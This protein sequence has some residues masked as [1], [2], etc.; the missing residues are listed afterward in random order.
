[1]WC[2]DCCS[3]C[4][5]RVSFVAVDVVVGVV[6]EIELFVW[7]C[8]VRAVVLIVLMFGVVAGCGV[9]NVDGGV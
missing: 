5:V 4:G 3:D 8:D 6:S 9:G 7:S 1:M 2:C